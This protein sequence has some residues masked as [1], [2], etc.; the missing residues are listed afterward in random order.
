MG[1]SS[2]K[3]LQIVQEKKEVTLQSTKISKKDD[4]TKIT[5]K[6]LIVSSNEPI[7][8]TYKILE[9][10]G[11][12]SFGQ[13]YKVQHRESKQLR[14]LKMVKKSALKY[15]DEK[16]DELIEIKIAMELEHPHILKLL[17]FRTDDKH[18]YIVS[19][20]MKGGELYDQISKISSYSEKN[21][22]IIIEQILSVLAYLHS[23]RI[24]HRD[25][26][27]EN[28]MLETNVQGD[29]SIKIIDFGTANYITNEPLK[30]KI[31]TAYYIAPEVLKKS[32]DEKCDLWSLG[33]ILYIL[34]CGFP[35]F[36]GDD[37]DAIM[38]NVEDGKFDFSEEEWDTV[39]QEAKSFIKR[40][41]T[42]DPKKRV[43]A[44]E[45][46][47]DPWLVKHKTSEQISTKMLRKPIENIKMFHHRPRFL[48]STLAFLT[49]Q[50]A[51]SDQ[52][53]KLREVFKELDL[54]NDGKLS[55]DELKN[56]YETFFKKLMKNEKNADE[57]FDAWITSMDQDRNGYIEYEEFLRAAIDMESICTEQNL[58]MAFNFFDTDNSG[59][60]SKEE[61]KNALGVNP[62]KESEESIKLLD[63]VLE[64]LDE[65][66]DNQI[67]FDEFKQLVRKIGK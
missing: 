58:K 63:E 44:K 51:S 17:E 65:N 61:I 13:V 19:E 16:S 9:K 64:E 41:L 8:K 42:Y 52:E 33:V 59:F 40:L 6:N 31:G 34:L 22:A 56:G 24:V 25:L 39:S 1:C 48:Q 67:S 11:A 28:I 5:T 54:N 20:L 62:D 36:D 3:T 29:L 53:K 47:K 50:M 15:Q 46:L 32:Y 7:T 23:K 18:F 35:P 4:G 21:A 45:A 43:S 66:G 57:E 27:P 60:L 26:K 2:S 49:H 55:Y 12:G 38:K 10:L 30:L 14:A 37:D